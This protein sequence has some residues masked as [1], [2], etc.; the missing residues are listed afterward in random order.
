MLE[1]FISNDMIC[2][3]I[4]EYEIELQS[5]GLSEFAS[6]FKEYGWDDIG[7]FPQM[8]DDDLMDCGMKAGHIAKFRRKYEKLPPTYEDINAPPKYNDYVWI[9][10]PGYLSNWLVFW[11]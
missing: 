1:N 3:E 11:K 10:I 5:L 2:W 4:L 6:K 8:S 7:L 9:F